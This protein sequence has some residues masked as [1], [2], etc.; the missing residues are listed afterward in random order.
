MKNLLIK[1]TNWILAGIIG[2]FGFAG[3]STDD[4]PVEYGTPS[5]DYTVKGA[6]VNEATGEPIPG[7][8]VGYYPQEWDEDVFGPQPQYWEYTAHVVTST[9]GEF[10]LTT[11]MF[12]LGSDKIVP[13]YVEDIDGE[14]NGSFGAKM[15]DVDF[16]DAVHSGNPGNWYSGMY[17][18]TTTI[19][20][21]EVQID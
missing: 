9:N 3:C 18:V 17:T 21:A 16:T 20:L 13:V 1:S 4:Y 12:P 2:L 10:T 14:E 19:Q 6:V 8:R 15:V 7:I 5:A 11:M